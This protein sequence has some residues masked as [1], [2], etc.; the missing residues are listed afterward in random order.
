MLRP[1]GLVT[2]TAV[3]TG[4]DA[5]TYTVSRV[6]WDATEGEYAQPTDSSEDANVT[7]FEGKTARDVANRATG[8]VDDV[9]PYW[10]Q[11]TIGGGHELIC[12][13]SCTVTAGTPVLFGKTTGAFTSGTTIVLDPCSQAGV[14]NGE[15]NITVH[16]RSDAGTAYCAIDSATVLR[17][18]VYSVAYGGVSGVLVGALPLLPDAG[19]QYQ[20]LQKNS[21]NDQDVKWDWVRGHA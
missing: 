18:V 3:G 4:D 6:Y 7:G 2:I 21:A 13:V 19:L 5:G 14:D 16:L 8:A 11:L 12:D 10:S 1:I 17:Y 9:V 15:A 20:V